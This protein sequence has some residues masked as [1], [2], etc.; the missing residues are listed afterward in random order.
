MVAAVAQHAPLAFLGAGV[1]MI[2][3]LRLLIR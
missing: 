1:A 2:G 3:I